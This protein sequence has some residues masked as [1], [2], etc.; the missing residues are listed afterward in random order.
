MRKIKPR[1]KRS[2]VAI[3]R[4]L[5]TPHGT[6]KYQVGRRHT[7]IFTPEGK[8]LVVDHSDMLSIPQHVVENLVDNAGLWIY[9]RDIRAYVDKLKKEAD[10]Q[11]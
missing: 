5:V 7:S 11:P 2:P 4:T 1:E 8:K 10:K 3:G 9:P 6:Y